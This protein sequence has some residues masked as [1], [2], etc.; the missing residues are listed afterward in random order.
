METFK[1]GSLD[2]TWCSLYTWYVFNLY[3]TLA[4][5]DKS[6][7][8]TYW[9]LRK[10]QILRT[11]SDLMVAL[12]QFNPIELEQGLSS[13]TAPMA[14]EEGRNAAGWHWPHSTSL[15]SE[16][17][18]ESE[19]VFVLTLTAPMVCK[20]AIWSPA[21][22]NTTKSGDQRPIA[23]NF[24]ILIKKK[25]PCRSSTWPHLQR[26]CRGRQLQQHW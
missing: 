17:K 14:G 23:K 19:L 1:H 22:Y 3:W 18:F 6:I 5:K 7:S 9:W 15:P 2:L 26:S 13:T 16:K 25:E 8:R 11:D 21:Y 20:S 12:Q 24:R 4:S 10:F